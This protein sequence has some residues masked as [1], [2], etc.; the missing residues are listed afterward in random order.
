M[1]VKTVGV[2]HIVSL[3]CQ[4]FK[5]FIQN[6]AKKKSFVDFQAWQTDKNGNDHF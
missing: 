1:F 6:R 3:H 4:I 2:K 5:D